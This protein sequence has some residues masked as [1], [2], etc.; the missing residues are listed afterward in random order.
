MRAKPGKLIAS[1]IVGVLALFGYKDTHDAE[2]YWGLAIFGLIA[3]VL[4]VLA[5]L[6]YR[7]GLSRAK[8]P[9]IGAMFLGGLCV[10]GYFGWAI[11]PNVQGGTAQQNVVPTPAP[12][13]APPGANQP[14]TA[15]PAPVG[16]NQ[17]QPAPAPAG[18][19]QPQ[20]AAGGV[21]AVPAITNDP[22]GSTNVRGGPGT[23]YP[24]AVTIAAGEQF[25]TQ[26]S[27][28][29]WW[30][31]TTK[32]G[33]VGYMHKSRIVVQGQDA[34]EAA[35]VTA[36]AQSTVANISGRWT[37][38]EDGT[39]IVM[40]QDG[41]RVHMVAT[42]QGIAIE[43]NGSLANRQLDLTLSMAG[44]NVGT[45]R[46]TLGPEG[47]RLQGTMDMQGAIERITFSR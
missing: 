19:N 9:A 16:A 36:R 7:K 46:M 33:V 11:N 26:P 40:T 27:S 45:L 8:W 44:V 13:P 34:A 21:A 4:A 20:I 30:P 29:P 39:V 3:L 35:P 18:A 38:S 41:N 17:P 12:A 43:G 37:D 31:V 32:A 5:Y 22:D 15:A 42:Q 6:D 25:L 2:T 24:I 10:V 47:R 23:N 1:Y 14:Q 28:G